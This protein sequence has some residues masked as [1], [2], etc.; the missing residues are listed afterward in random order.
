MNK[1]DTCERRIC[2]CDKKLAENLA[3]Y[4]STWNE[5]FHTRL[6]DGTWKYN[7]QCKKKGLGRYGKPQTCCGNTFPDMTPKQQVNITI[8]RYICHQNDRYYQPK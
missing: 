6:G 4:E 5:N 1:P 3:K 7:E 2:E 8:C